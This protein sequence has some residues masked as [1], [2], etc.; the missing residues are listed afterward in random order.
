MGL[1][2]RKVLVD[3]KLLSNK[4]KIKKKKRKLIQI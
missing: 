2:G 1:K 4:S 3:T